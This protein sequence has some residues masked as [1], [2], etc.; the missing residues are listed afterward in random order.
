MSDFVLPM[1]PSANRYWRHFRG[2][3]VVSDEA[4][5]YRGVASMRA[6][7]TG[8]R[9]MDCPVALTLV[10][11][12]IRSDADVSNRIKILEDALN[13]VAYADDKQVAMLIVV[14]REAARVKKARKGEKQ[15]KRQE[16]V[17]VRAEPARDAV[18]RS[19]EASFG[20]L[21]DDY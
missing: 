14:R 12:L 16:Y 7:A 6:F 1:P 10:F 11:Y 2:M 13:G 3:M 17:L 4:R 9:P 18:L 21:K 5:T 15:L 20:G 8:L 19:V